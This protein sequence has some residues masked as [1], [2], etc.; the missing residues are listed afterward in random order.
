MSLS[1][2]LWLDRIAP[3]LSIR[4]QF[5]ILID[6]TPHTVR[7]EGLSSAIARWRKAVTNYRTRGALI[8]PD[9]AVV[10]PV[11]RPVDD[12]P[13]TY[14]DWIALNEPSAAELA[15]QRQ[16]ASKSVGM[17]ISLII[18]VY[19]PPTHVLQDVVASI[20]AQTYPHWQLCISNGS[21][22][23]AGVRTV[24]DQS[25]QSDDRIIVRHLNA[26][27]G[28]S[29]NSN[30]ALALAE[31]EYVALVDH[32]DMLAPNM[33]YEV[34]DSLSL[35]PTI[36]IVYFDE[37]KL[38][39]DGQRRVD[40]WFKPDFSPD[41][42]LSTNL[43][44]HGVY[45][46][47]LIEKAGGFDDATNG[48]QDWDLALRCSRLTDRI[49]H[50]PKVLYHWRQIAGS[51]SVDA[52]AKPYAFKAQQVALVRHIEALDGMRPT[53]E[54]P[55]IG[56]ARVIWPTRGHKVSI[57]IPTKDNVKLLRACIQSIL[58]KTDYPEYE[59]VLVDTGSRQAETQRYYTELQREHDHVTVVEY[60]GRFNYSH[61]NNVG[62]KAAT[63]DL[64]LFLNNDTE[65]L[66]ADWLRE[67]AGWA[68]R[69]GVGVVGAK[70]LRPTGLIQHAGIVMG[71]TG[72]GSHIF[73]DMPEDTYT[74][75]GS[76]EWV[77]NYHALTGACM[78]V[79]SQLFD[80][81][82]GFDEIYQIGYSDIE[83]CLR[84]EKAGY[85]NVFTP[86]A[87]LLHHEGGSRGFYLPPSDVLR[88]SCQF[89]P[90]IRQGDRYFN[91]NLS[92]DSRQPAFARPGE[93]AT[94]DVVE[95][96]RGHRLLPPFVPGISQPMHDVELT[97]PKE[98]PIT[99]STSPNKRM[100]ELSLLL[101]THDLSLSG[102]PLLLAALA[103]QL[104]Q[105]GVQCK[106]VSPMDGPTRS[107]FEAD[108]VPVD[109]IPSMQDFHGTTL[110]TRPAIGPLTAAV[111]DCDL[112]FANS[113]VSSLAIHTAT[114]FNVPS[115]YWLHESQF[116]LK[117]VRKEPSVQAALQDATTII[118]PTQ[119]LA[120]LYADYLPHTN[121]VVMPYGLEQATLVPP[122]DGVQ[123]PPE[124]ITV[125][126]IGSLEPRKGQEF[127]LTAIQRLPDHV[128]QSMEFYFLGRTIDP[129]YADELFAQTANI[130]NVHF[131]G[132]LAHAEI[133]S[134]LDAADIFVLSS[135]DEV[136]PVSMLEAMY[137]R[138]A[139]IATRAGG[140]AEAI[141]DGESG[142]LVD[143]GATQRMS[144]ALLRLA[145]D[146]VL[147]QQLGERAG[148]VFAERYTMEIFMQRITEIIE[149]TVNEAS[150]R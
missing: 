63:G 16:L 129:A 105:C 131:T 150:T 125:V 99:P 136:L 41:M 58:A 101:V 69:D 31:G 104:M 90:L 38:S 110:L 25:A 10:T 51:A 2:R 142:L 135:R 71:L 75:F 64:L 54:F 115:I 120:D 81:L 144:D 147:H 33:L 127:L 113:V 27:L 9:D 1:R 42:M 48:A 15:E 149:K 23:N 82:G 19:N 62:A 80:G 7:E 53:V 43:L 74:I 118:L 29:G 119:H 139:I 67:L 70:L 17:L 141:V 108:G 50:I 40:P 130:A 20:Q 85:R 145:G 4:R 44:M 91:P 84:A 73:E 103:R 94:A 143:F 146:N 56:R 49:H 45:R 98:W 72:H 83:F 133:M 3:P 124:K 112:V 111:A 114:A 116:G 47:T 14:A 87:R 128:R 11:V 88:A 13:L 109:I 102:A 77:R 26:N 89:L 93:K 21:G 35:Q 8:A 52:G 12:T 138:K 6:E 37:D 24:L 137:H 123:L 61:A 132:N 39:E 57:I 46:R 134:Y 76:T 92:V 22:D 18:P 36:D 79:S 148:H 30:A 78:M 65:V 66:H 126:N 107:H 106:L 28:I 95:I 32:D 86:F 121:T 34:A 68:G 5:L 97:Q 140:V 59:I 122:V 96:M 55:S 100:H 60:H 117:T